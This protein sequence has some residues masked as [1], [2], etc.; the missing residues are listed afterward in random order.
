MTKRI[1][2]VGNGAVGHS[3]AHQL[4]ETADRPEVVVFGPDD[5]ASHFAGSWAAPAMVNVF[6]EMTVDHENSWAGQHMLEIGI[7]AMELWPGFLERLNAELKDLGEPPVEL[8]RGTYIVSRPGRSKENRNLGA[9]R[10]ALK[11]HGR[12]YDDL[13]MDGRPQGPVIEPGRFE[14]GIY[15]PDEMFVDAR[16]V[17]R[18]LRASLERKPN[19]TFRDAQVRE[20]DAETS[21]LVDDRGETT[22]ADAIVLANSFGFNELVEGMGL[23]GA[24]PH[25]L[26]VYGVGLR[27]EAREGGSAAVVRTPVYG[28][29]CGDYAVQQPGFTYVGASALTNTDRVEMTTQ[30]QRSL[31]FYDPNAN[32]NGLALTGGIRAMAQDTYPLIGRLK[33]DVFAAAGFFKSGVTLAPYAADLLSRE[34]TGQPHNYSNRFNP[35]R[36][37]DEEPPSLTELTQTIWDEI[38]SSAT[39][40]GSR[41]Q[42][43]RYGWL[44]R[45]VVR[46][47]VGRTV[48]RFKKGIY[49]NS[50]IV[51]ACIYDSG[52]LDRLNRY[53]PSEG[54]SGDA[55]GP[56]SEPPAPD[57]K[58]A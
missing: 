45:P 25:L 22:E 7:A 28:S 18:G 41:K 33:G 52:L 48:G 36:H 31:D 43:N 49:Y 30:V 1:A 21:R 58:A 9:V 37:V 11:A 5:I 44:A 27:S 12:S 23:A 14:D 29:S 55:R 34:I 10:R 32:L 19:V 16:A 4:A 3:L 17:V 2:I 15:V 38:E 24:V 56:A 54:K 40:G 20:V 47:R 57:R 50:D 46:W 35:Y 13:A 26:R 42:L 51:Q 6:G 39:S 8:H 53:E